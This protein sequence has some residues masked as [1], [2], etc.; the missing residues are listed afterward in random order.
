MELAVAVVL[1]KEQHPLFSLWRAKFRK[2]FFACT[3]RSGVVYYTLVV[4]YMEVRPL[5]RR[6]YDV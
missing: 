1:A 3:L 2:L 5:S 4:T 6:L